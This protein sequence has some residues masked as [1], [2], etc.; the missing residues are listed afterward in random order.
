VR[1]L[2]GDG[3]DVDTWADLAAAERDAVTPPR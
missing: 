3:V 1:D 2:A